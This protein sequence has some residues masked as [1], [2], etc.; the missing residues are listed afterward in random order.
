MIIV[1][2]DGEGGG[3]FS[4]KNTAVACSSGLLRDGEVEGYFF[5]KREAGR[6][7]AHDRYLRRLFLPIQ[8]AVVKFRVTSDQD[9]NPI[10]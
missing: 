2:P 5:A 7:P 1:S 4:G 10:E 3:Y 8:L 6:K 9:G